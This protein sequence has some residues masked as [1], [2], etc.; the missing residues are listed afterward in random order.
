ML[1]EK[2]RRVVP[3]FVL[4][5]ETGSMS[6]LEFFGAT[7]VRLLRLKKGYQNCTNPTTNY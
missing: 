5:Q 3:F 4:Q 7:V 1:A 6:S 2:K